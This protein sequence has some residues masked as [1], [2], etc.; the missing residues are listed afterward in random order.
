MLKDNSWAKKYVDNYQTASKE[1]AKMY[2][3]I[4]IKCTK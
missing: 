3:S 1:E 4:K 2:L